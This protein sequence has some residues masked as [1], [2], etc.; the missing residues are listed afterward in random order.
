MNKRETSYPACN[1]NVSNLCC[2]GSEAMLARCEV[3]DGAED[4]EG[5]TSIAMSGSWRKR[6]S[7]GLDKKK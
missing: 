7:S 6:Q 5:R 1:C 4:A 2:G 3:G